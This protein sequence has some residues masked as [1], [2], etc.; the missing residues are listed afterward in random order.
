MKLSASRLA[1]AGRL[2]LLS[3]LVLAMTF[4]LLAVSP[5]DPMLYY[6]SDNLFA[7]SAEHTAQFSGTLGLDQPLATR[8]HQW[9]VNLMQG[10]LGFSISQQQPVIEVLNQRVPLTL[11]L[12]VMGW[13]GS[14]LLGY[15]S[16][17]LAAIYQ[18]RIVDRFIQGLSW[19][20]ASAPAFW[21]ALLALSL[22]G[23]T[24]QW[25]PVCCGAPIGV[26]PNA[27]SWWQ[28]MPYLIMPTL[29]LSLSGM[30]HVAMHTRERALQVLAS[31][32]VLYARLQGKSGW[33]I[34]RYHLFRNTLTPAVVLQFAGLS[35]LLGG[36]ALIE[37]VFNFPG[38]GMTM[39]VA[40]L[41]GDIALLMA[42]TL[43]SMLLVFAGNALAR[44]ISM[45]LLPEG[46][47]HV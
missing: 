33:G 32:H 47:G 25:V 29:V 28:Q 31:E 35:E 39:V 6:T 11:R 18:G 10:D 30:S 16:G 3:A 42:I 14:L 22:F 40:G 44:L 20:T 5:I 19:V 1:I 23:V 24:L 9:G 43:L 2:T 27:M 13:L 38:I 8:F 7:M 26:S 15:S 17:I 36:S 45:K 34:Y 12:M 41:N 46:R 21:I 4:T 37:T